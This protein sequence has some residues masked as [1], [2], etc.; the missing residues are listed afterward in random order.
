MPGGASDLPVLPFLSGLYFV[1]PVSP[2][3][4]QLCNAGRTVVMSASAGDG[5]LAALL[6]SLDGRTSIDA[7]LSL[8]S[9]DFITTVISGLVDRGLVADAACVDLVDADRSVGFYGRM[10]AH[11][12]RRRLSEVT[13]ALSDSGPI[14]R[15]VASLLTEAG[16]GQIRFLADA[17]TVAKADGVLGCLTLKEGGAAGSG[18]PDPTSGVALSSGASEPSAR[19]PTASVCDL[20]ESDLTIV[21]LSYGD[22]RLLGSP[23][24]DA[25][26]QN[27]R[28]YLAYFQESTTAIIGPYHGALRDPCHVCV[29]LRRK[30]HQLHFES[31]ERL[32][33]FRARAF[34]GPLLFSAANAAL[35]ASL[36]ALEATRAVLGFPP[37]TQQAVLELDLE[38]LM[39]RRLSISPAPSCR[40]CHDA[41]Q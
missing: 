2:G 26:L 32:R 12:T 38:T 37:V 34:P 7:L 31:D 29:D 10:P 22:D 19:P 30:A 5:D 1:V 3:K 35:I 39:T 23:I 41:H 16:V 8:F 21:E 40:Q 25:S 33:D 17:S 24:A 20:T 14:G 36:V 6:S 28:P 15:L 18:G 27:G 13:V 9:L 11:L 4:V